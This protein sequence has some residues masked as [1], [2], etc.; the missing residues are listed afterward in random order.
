MSTAPPTLSERR[1]NYVASEI[2]HAAMQ[3]FATHGFDAVTV[4]EI[5]EA[6]GISARTFF[7]YFAT[8]D[9][10]VL[11]YRR[12][13]QERLV[14]AVLARPKQEGAVTALRNAYLET[15]TTPV[16]DRRQVA[17]RNRVLFEAPSLRGRAHDEAASAG[18]ALV[19]A[20][21]SRMGVDARDDRP[22]A[23]AAGTAAVA[24]VAFEQWVRSGGRGDPAARVRDALDLLIAGFATLDRPPARRRRA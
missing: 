13:L 19:V 24:G 16:A 23:L 4:D 22:L 3:L 6:A 5:A 20:L 11:Q 18:S 2:S 8:K 9:D 17:L 7:R 14:A 10:V 12:R 21:A 15:S 1:R